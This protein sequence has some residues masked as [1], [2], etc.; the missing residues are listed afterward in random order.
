[1]TEKTETP[2]TSRKSPLFSRRKRSDSLESPPTPPSPVSQPVIGSPTLITRSDTHSFLRNL[3]RR[4]SSNSVCLP[5]PPPAVA[6]AV[7]AAAAAQPPQ[8]PTLIRKQQSGSTSQNSLVS[9]TGPAL[10]ASPS[11]PISPAVVTTSFVHFVW[12]LFYLKL[13]FKQKQV[14]SGRMSQHH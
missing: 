2:P 4:P 10:A 9:S 3:I 12:L 6:A 1:M 5:S 8:S 11:R 7:A 13:F 14:L